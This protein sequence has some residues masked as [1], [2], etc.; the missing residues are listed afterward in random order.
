MYGCSLNH[1]GEILRP[2]Q[3]NTSPET[4]LKARAPDREALVVA[5]EGLLTWSWLADLCAQEQLPCVLGHA[6]SLT[7]L[8]GG[9]AQHETLD[10]QNIAV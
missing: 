4:L 7:A 9:N 3:M 8:H 1:D 6:L 5:V 10:A 2:H